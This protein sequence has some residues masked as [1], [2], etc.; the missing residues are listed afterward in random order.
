MAERGP[1]YALT[2][3]IIMK[4]SILTLIAAMCAATA[5]AQTDTIATD[6]AP[7]LQ[8]NEVVVT[9]RRPALRQ[10]DGKL[11]YIVKNDPYSQGLDGMQVLGRIPRVSA[12]DGNV[13]VAGKG[14]VRYIIDG[15]L[16]ELDAAAMKARLQ[17]IRAENIEKIELITT[18]PARYATEANAVFI[19]IT[20]RNETLGTRGS[21]YGSLNQG[22]RFRQHFNGSVSHTTRR[23]E[24]SLDANLS[25]YPT[26]ND[27]S[28]TYTFADATRTSD[29][30]NRSRN[31]DT[32]V[33]ALF[34]YKFT[35]DISAGFIANYSYGKSS[36]VGTNLTDYGKY[37]SSSITTTKSRPNN[38][39]TVTGFYDWQFGPAGERLELTYNYFNRHSPTRSTITTTFG[40]ASGI[41]EIDE[42]GTSDYRFHSGKADLTLP[43]RWARIETGAAYTDI[44]NSS[45]LLTGRSGATG[46]DVDFDYRERIA[47][48]HFSAS[49]PLG[50]EF[51]AK[52]GLRYEYT[53]TDGSLSA[54]G[55]HSRHDYGHLFP[56][57][58]LSWSKPG[59]GSV[60][61]SYSMGMQR[62]NLWELNPFRYYST[63]DEYSAG[64]P[65][66]RPTIFNNAEISYYGLGGLYAV[67]YT[68]FASDALGYIRRFDADGTVSTMPYNCLSTNKTGLYAS[69]RRA[70]LPRWEM[71]A[72][73]EAFHTHSH[74][75][76]PDYDAA[77]LDNFSGK[78]E[79]STDAMLNRARTLVFSARFSHYFPWQ[80]NMIR[81]DSFQMLTLSLRYSMLAGRL[82][83]RLAA[84][85]IFGWNKTRSTQHYASYTLRQ[86]FDGRPAYVL[87]G[88]S[89]TFGRDKVA[90]VWRNTKEDQSSRTK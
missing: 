22:D 8:L 45:Y 1:F 34:R 29:T 37:T 27:N 53:R 32:G 80:Q 57:A 55:E 47:A 49:R 52:I 40:N 77:S 68:S 9:G 2:N 56:S 36:T 59:K 6:T 58:T 63:T 66:L 12:S 33:N 81:Y 83:L 23:V 67:L 48:V 30:R 15:I 17:N 74:S 79:L 35:P 10:K 4:T 16:M 88:V 21:V 11:V 69:Y 46:E 14:N 86:I 76:M 43:C 26:V 75:N 20:T 73:A 18:P 42:R 89:Y 13:S 38:A 54:S 39:V 84:N 24:M 85:D 28:M 87:L 64:N 62:P 7:Q 60:N 41:D 90:G 5:T 3:A 51:N 19:S 72:G 31:F 78:F 50:S 82:N 65:A 71:T 25:N 70:I 44:L 61:I